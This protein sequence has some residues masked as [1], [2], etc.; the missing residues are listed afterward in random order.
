MG[1]E[2]LISSHQHRRIRVRL[3]VTSGRVSKSM[4]K[5]EREAAAGWLL[6]ERL[7]GLSA[8]ET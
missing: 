4:D 7:T 2:L 8:V 3:Y 5:K 6:W 1:E